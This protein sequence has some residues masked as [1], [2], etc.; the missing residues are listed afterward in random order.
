MSVLLAATF[1]I[2]TLVAPRAATPT[3]EMVVRV[4]TGVLA[5]GAEIDVRD[6][7]GALLGTISPFG[8]RGGQSA[9]TYTIPLGAIARRA[10]VRLVLTE[11]GRPPRA[12]TSRE[13]RGVTLDF[14]AVTR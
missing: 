11:A 4:Q 2:W 9:G 3:E 8:L 12:P 6:A 5:H 1:A 14:I 13:V 7:R 10:V